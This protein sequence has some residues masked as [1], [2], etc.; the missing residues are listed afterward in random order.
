MENN[1]SLHTETNMYWQQPTT[2]H[3]NKTHCRH[4]YHN[5]IFTYSTQNTPAE[6]WYQPGGTMIASTGTIAACHLETGTVPTGM[7]QSSYQNNRKEWQENNFHLRYR[8]D[9]IDCWGST[10]FFHQWH[11]LTKLGH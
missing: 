6:Q 7:G 3:L 9:N 8:V 5:P 2:K 4:L 11:K 10:S 1:I